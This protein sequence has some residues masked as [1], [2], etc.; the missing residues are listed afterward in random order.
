MSIDFTL[1][2]P[3]LELRDAAREFVQ[4][5]LAPLVPDADATPGPHEAFDQTGI[6][7]G[8]QTRHRHGLPPAGWSARRRAA[9]AAP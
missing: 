9:P 1:T 5:V 4:N 6:C 3:Q 2:K 8:I 7:R